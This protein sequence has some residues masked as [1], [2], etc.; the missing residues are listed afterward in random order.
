MGPTLPCSIPVSLK[1]VPLPLLVTFILSSIKYKIWVWNSFW[2]LTVLRLKPQR[3]T[4]LFFLLGVKKNKHYSE[5]RF[6]IFD[7]SFALKITDRVRKLEKIIWNYSNNRMKN[8]L[9]AE[10]MSCNL[11]LHPFPFRVHILQASIYD[12][13][14][15]WWCSLYKY[16]Y[17][18]PHPPN[19]SIAMIC[20]NL[21]VI[22]KHFLSNRYVI[23]SLRFI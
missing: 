9:S 13:N 15:W 21:F 17:P 14:N 8:P 2:R 19:L 10:Q 22:L 23:F 6:G 16:K 7:R 20:I 11:W 12:C 1:N 5:T 4:L 3:L 18:R